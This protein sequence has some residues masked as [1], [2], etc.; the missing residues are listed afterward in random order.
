MAKV[1]RYKWR[2]GGLVLI[3]MMLS[4]SLSAQHNHQLILRP[5]DKETPNIVHGVPLEQ[6]FSNLE[7]CLKYIDKLIPTLQAQ[8]Y[9]AASLDSVATVDSQTIAHIFFGKKYTG[10]AVTIHEADRPV[11]NA[12]GLQNSFFEK[13][14]NFEA[15]KVTQ[16]KLLDYFENNG[17]PFA[18]VQLDSIVVDNENIYGNLQI[19]K[20]IFYKIDSIRLKGP[21]RISQNFI[22]K[23]LGIEKGSMYRKQ[24]LAKINQRLLELPYLQQSQPWDMNMLNSGSVVNLY[25][26]SK[27]SNQVNVLAGFLPANQQLGGK[28]LFTIDANLQLQNA[29]SS[30]EKIGVMWQQIQPKSPRLDLQYT[31]PYI[32]KSSFGLDLL[33]ELYKKD[34]SFLNINGQ[35]GL[36]YSLSANKTIKLIVQSQSTTVL[37]LDTN[38]VKITRQLPSVAD[39]SSLNIG[40]DYEIISTDY[41]FNPRRGTEFSLYAGVGQKTVKKNSNITSIKEP[42]YDFNHLYDT[43]Q[44][45]AYQVRTRLRA[46]KYFP[47]GKQS[48]IKTGLQAG[49]YQ[50]P[51]AFR[52]ELFQVGGYRLLRGFDEESIY[53]STYAVGTLEYRYLLG[54]NRNFFTFSDVGWTNNTINSQANFYIGAGVG[55]S[56]ETKGGIF[57]I[58]YAA[59]KRNDLNFDIRQSKIHVG[60]VSV[61]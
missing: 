34:S 58:S 24:A 33:F 59:G 35:I 27:R 44:L 21:L 36:L 39:V 15:F 11:L 53:A 37:D 26:Q 9:I 17:Y 41:R 32:F 46:A 57:N 48:V 14:L 6:T 60:Y 51:N 8:G 55:L 3:F 28:L 20:G 22:Y 49:W 47:L 23:Y 43:V 25:L 18:S 19:N 52:N 4:M 56:F 38:L 1:T 2:G 40:I 10:A 13:P 5:V 61:F 7:L 54:L 30:G 42:G 50:S 45:K 16:E 29:F 31:Q 12:A